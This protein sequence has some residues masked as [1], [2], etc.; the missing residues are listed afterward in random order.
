ML[1]HVCVVSLALVLTLNLGGLLVQEGEASDHGWNNR[2]VLETFEYQGIGF[3]SF[4]LPFDPADPERYDFDR[5][6][7]EIH[8]DPAP[9]SGESGASVFHVEVF[10][11]EGDSVCDGLLWDFFGFKGHLYCDGLRQGHH[12]EITIIGTA[13]ADLTLS[14]VNPI[15][16]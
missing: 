11:L 6:I 16:P 2:E 8:A 10:T 4:V 13:P 15:G 5:Y 3:E 7:F 12:Y 1:R 9:G 14:G